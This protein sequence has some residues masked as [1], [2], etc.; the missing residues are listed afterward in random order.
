M[1]KTIITLS[2][3][4]I[5]LIGSAQKMGMSC[6]YFPALQTGLVSVKT[7][8]NNQFSKYRYSAPVPLMLIDKLAD[9]W[10][11]NL[12]FSSFYYSATQ[13]NKAN[14][15]R[16]KISKAEGALC[17]GRIGYGFGDGEKF[18]I[19]P[20]GSIGLSTSNL[21]SIN[22][23]FKQRSYYNLGLGVVGLRKF[24]KF[25]VMGKIGYDIY[26]R[27]SYVNKG[28]GLYF[29]GTIGYSFYQKYGISV[30]PCFYSKKMEYMPKPMNG[31]LATTPAT[32]KVKSFVLRIGLTKF[33]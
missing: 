12:D 15:D 16:I 18:R 28:H 4:L 21:D 1:K 10:Y 13:T 5:A 26:K 8:G 20:Y 32:A 30:M 27:K 24:G 2:L 9:H 25:R 19:G 7:T 29:E 23:P 14:D 3:L 11:T 6:Q 17:S 22:R 31:E 33:F